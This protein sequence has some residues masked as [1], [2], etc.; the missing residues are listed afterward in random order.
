MIPNS[1]M[2]KIN[3]SS[4]KKY[5]ANVGYDF[6]IGNEYEIPTSI[7]PKG[8]HIEL[9]CTCDY[10]GSVKMKPYKDYLESISSQGLYACKDC[11]KI[12]TKLTNLEK[13]GYSSPSCTDE[14]KK[15]I[16]NTCMERYGTESAIGS[17][18]VKAKIT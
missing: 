10:C 8:S 7:L 2:I 14:V 16:K 5:Y 15:R 6:N 3:T 17:D 11:K 18:I 4:Q 13:Y 12:K 9:P 1:I